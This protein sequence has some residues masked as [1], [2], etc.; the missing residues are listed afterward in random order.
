MLNKL[1]ALN[2]A[3]LQVI[4]KCFKN[5]YDILILHP[6]EGNINLKDK[7]VAICEESLSLP[8]FDSSELQFHYEY[9]RKFTTLI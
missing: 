9:K 5:L 8:C 6:I 2:T 7:I 1:Q 3:I 4:N